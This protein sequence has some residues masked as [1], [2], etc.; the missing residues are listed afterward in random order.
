MSIGNE[1]GML[2]K[3]DDQHVDTEENPDQLGKDIDIV[4][5]NVEESEACLGHCKHI[6]KK[7]Q[8][9]HKVDEE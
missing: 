6:I 4:N 7:T 3:D 8:G 5:I 9:Q 1:I 2:D